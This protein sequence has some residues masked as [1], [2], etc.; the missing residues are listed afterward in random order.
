MAAVSCTGCAW[1]TP[2][3]SVSAAVLDI[4]PT[5]HVFTTVD[6]ALAMT[7]EHWFFLAQPPGFPERLIGADP[8]FYLRTKLAAWSA[9]G[10]T[11][12]PA[13]VEQYL[14]HFRDPAAIAASC[15]DYRAAASIDLDHDE[16]SYTRGDR[17]TCPLLVMWGAAGFVGRHYDPAAVWRSYAT[18]VSTTAIASSAHF[19]AEEAPAATAAALTQ[20]LQ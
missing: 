19:L 2:L 20:F 8:E 16:A 9:D 14:T 3:G 18:D 4:V 13:A 15:E 17:V 12:D 6:M 7:Y 1:I 10:H 5:R 11:F